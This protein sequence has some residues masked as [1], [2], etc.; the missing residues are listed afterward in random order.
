VTFSTALVFLASLLTL[1]LLNLLRVNKGF[2]EKRAAVID[3]DLPDLQYPDRASRARFFERAL[4]QVTALPGVRSAAIVQGLPLTGETMVNGIELESSDRDWIDPST[5]APILVNVRFVS[6]DYFQT[7]GIPLLK[8]RS[9]EPEDR[10]RKVA[11][12]SE[13]LAS[14]IW[15]GQNSLGKKFKTGSQVGEAQVVGIVGDT[16]N[17][18]LDEQPTLIVYAPFWI[19]PPDGASLVFRTAGIPEPLI[20]SVQ[21]A[22]WS[23][24]PGISVSEV[25]T[26]S[27]I[28]WAASAQRCFQMQL[29][30]TFGVAALFLTLIG[31]YGVV[32]YNVEQRK[33]ELGLRLA[34]GAR[35]LELIPLMIEYGLSPVFIGVGFGLVLSVVIGRLARSLV[36]GLSPSDPVIIFGVCL[37]LVFSAGIACLVPAS[38]VIRLEP[39]SI[40][41]HD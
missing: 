37:L 4:A 31:I 30:A 28:V 38:R 3:L 27:E 12:L 7:L 41:R 40:L 21:R 39:A 36:F 19:R 17:G 29:A 34:L 33:G 32:S 15:P 11:V 16:Y 22:I 14:K 2:E 8:G 23:I 5:K 25:R 35:H 20:H 26:L 18:R 24:D 10:T 6:P 13:R 9:I 1:S